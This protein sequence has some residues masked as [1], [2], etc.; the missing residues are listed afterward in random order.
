MFWAGLWRGREALGEALGEDP[1]Q[2]GEA[3]VPE[4]A[5]G[6]AALGQKVSAVVGVGVLGP[7][8]GVMGGGGAEEIKVDAEHGFRPGCGMSFWN[9]MDRGIFRIRNF[10]E[11][12][13]DLTCRA[14][15][16]CRLCPCCGPLMPPRAVGAL[17]KRGER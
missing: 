12:K 15:V 2:A 3:V 7:T 5:A 11:T 16:N 4:L 17:L 8:I 9:A 13:A 10:L 6:S 14:G 1:A